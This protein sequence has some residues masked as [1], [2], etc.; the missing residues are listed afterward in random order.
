MF[1]LRELDRRTTLHE[2]S[3]D[4]SHGASGRHPVEVLESTQSAPC[5][6]SPRAVSVKVCRASDELHRCVTSIGI[7]LLAAEARQRCVSLLALHFARTAEASRGLEVV[8]LSGV[9]D[10][11]RR[12]C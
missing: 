11:T 2:R 12:A 4:W 8:A 3:R 6:S 5:L 7:G 1:A 9:F 10:L